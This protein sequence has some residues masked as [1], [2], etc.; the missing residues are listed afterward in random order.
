MSSIALRSRSGPTLF[1]RHA[2]VPRVEAPTDARLL[3]RNFL[4]LSHAQL[5]SQF[6]NQAFTI[7]LTFWTA[8]TTHSATMTGLMMM[9][10]RSRR[11]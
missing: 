7:A 1:S 4:L 2:A 9:A 10:G 3:N 8:A 5:V 6:G 11:N